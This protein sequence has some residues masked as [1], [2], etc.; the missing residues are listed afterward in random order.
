LPGIRLRVFCDRLMLADGRLPALVTTRAIVAV[1]EE[2]RSVIIGVAACPDGGR[3][4]TEIGSFGLIVDAAKPRARLLP[5]TRQ[6]MDRAIRSA[7]KQ[8][9]TR[10]KD[11][12]RASRAHQRSIFSIISQFSGADHFWGEA[13]ASHVR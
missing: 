1:L 13:L 7:S 11:W 2:A 4:A 8:S 6:L 9:R 10:S 5:S 3:C 12:E